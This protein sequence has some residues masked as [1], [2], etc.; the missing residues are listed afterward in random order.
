MLNLLKQYKTAIFI[1][2]H[3]SKNLYEA[4]LIELIDNSIFSP[5]DIPTTTTTV[6]AL[7]PPPPLK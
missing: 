7:V 1:A 3:L 5:Q 4:L 6:T 2:T